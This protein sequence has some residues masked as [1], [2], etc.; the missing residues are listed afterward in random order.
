MSSKNY[1][2]RL[3]YVKVM[4]KVA[5]W[6]VYS[7]IEFYIKLIIYTVSQKSTSPFL[8]RDAHIANA[9]LLSSVVRPSVRPSVRDVHVPWALGCVGFVRK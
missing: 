1:E 6:D 3:T 5:S 2:N 4:H 8:P 9:V 7:Y